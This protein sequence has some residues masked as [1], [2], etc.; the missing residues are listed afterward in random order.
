MITLKNVQK[1][2]LEELIV[3]E[4]EGFTKEEAA[5][6]EAFMERIK[7]IPHTFIVAEKEGVNSWLY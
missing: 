7:V 5:T 4:N 3:I 1:T 6:K 2:D